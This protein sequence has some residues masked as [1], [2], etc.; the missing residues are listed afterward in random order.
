MSYL[1]KHYDCDFNPLV[2]LNNKQDV[3]LVLQSAALTMKNP[4]HSHRGGITNTLFEYVIDGEGYINVDGVKRNVSKGD[5]II[6]RGDKVDPK[7]F[8]FGSSTDNP[9]SKLSFHANGSFINGMFNAF[10]VTDAVTIKKNCGLLNFFQNFVMSL[11]KDH[12][13]S[14]SC[15]IAIAT[16]MDKVYNNSDDL[17]VVNNFDNLVDNYIERNFQFPPAPAKMAATLGITQ[18][19]LSKYFKKRFNTTYRQYM[20][21]KRLLYA[22]NALESPY[23]KHSISKI[24]LNLGFCDQSYFSKCFYKEFGVYPTEYRQ[25]IIEKNKNN[26]DN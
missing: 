22:K 10:G 13:D 19:A 17:P 2:V 23:Q 8:C 1:K 21:T 14:L 9:Y 20:R 15:M 18:K 16:I 4:N 6:I 3:L 11:T 24:A 7:T 5:C 12:F 25:Q 26:R